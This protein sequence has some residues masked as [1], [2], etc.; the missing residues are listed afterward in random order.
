MSWFF[1]RGVIMGISL[2]LLVALATPLISSFLRIDASIIILISPILFI[3]TVTMVCRSFLQGTLRFSQNVITLNV[4]MIGRLTIG[5][6]LVYLGFSVFGALVGL[7]LAFT[8]ALFLSLYFLRNYNILQTKEK[9]TDT[10]KVLKY[11]IPIFI[12]AVAGNSFFSTD[13]LLVKHFFSPHDAGL[14]ASLST[15][16]K[17]IFFGTAPI[18]AVMFPM[19]SKRHARGGNYIKIFLMSMVLTFG[20][21]GVVLVLYYLFPEIAVGA[22]YGSEFLEASGNLFWFGLF[23]TLFSLSSLI[24]SFYLSLEKTKVV[25]PLFVA[26]VLQ[27]VG[28]WIYH[29]TILD[30][31]MVSTVVA[32]GLLVTLLSYF[33]YETYK[34]KK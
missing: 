19:V 3:S 33:I 5:F 24:V 28:I 15:L 12:A 6:I 21:A 25:I 22:L 27:A 30:V 31:V 20:G 23:F 18:A 2:A 1:K 34:L 10:R 8:L 29:D 11:S 32:S 14:Y 16:G 7:L 26:A 4:E 13:L 17:I 9:F